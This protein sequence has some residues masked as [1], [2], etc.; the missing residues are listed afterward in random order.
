MKNSKKV[1]SNKTMKFVSLVM[2]V[3]V[4]AAIM[5]AGT[6]AKYTSTASGTATA[7]VAKWD[8]S[9]GALGEEV[10][11]TGEDATVAFNLFDTILEEDGVTEELD[12]YAE[13]GK[14]V[15]I[16]PGTSGAF[17]LSVL[18]NSEVTAAY[19]IEFTVDRTDIPLQ[20]N[21]NNAGWT[22][23]LDNV[24]ET[25]IAMGS[26]STANVQWKWAFEG[27]NDATDTAL[28]IEAP[29]IIV[30]ATLN[31]VQYDASEG[32]G[33][34]NE[35]PTEDLEAYALLSVSS[36]AAYQYLPEEAVGIPDIVSPA[37]NLYFEA[38]TTITVTSE[39]YGFYIMT[40]TGEEIT[41]LSGHLGVVDGMERDTDGT[42]TIN[43]AGWYGIAI[44]NSDSSAFDTT[45]A[46]GSYV[47]F[48]K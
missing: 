31:V 8:I 38:G 16:A 30:T 25:V 17:D 1:N 46:L 41:Q 36:D 11:I 7:T 34:T 22:T 21:V 29:E 48:S 24:T 33:S 9:A 47:T 5:I 18:N 39:D 15:R 35:E 23:T 37:N 44:R 40:Q 32:A 4:V 26:S 45:E 20:F 42:Y 27:G 19:T 14:V 28:G 12:V 3:T 6:F 10:S 13:D 43:T 2:L